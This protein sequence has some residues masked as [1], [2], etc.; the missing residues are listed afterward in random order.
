[1]DTLLA[2]DA[3]YQEEMIYMFEERKVPDSMRRLMEVVFGNKVIYERP[4]PIIPETEENPEPE[5]KE[6]LISEEMETKG[7]TTL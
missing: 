5:V 7:E 6:E 4:A 2:F 1:M 3:M